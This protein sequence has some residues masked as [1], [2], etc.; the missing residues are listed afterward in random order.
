MRAGGGGSSSSQVP[1]RREVRERRARGASERTTWGRSACGARGTIPDGEGQGGGRGA[2]GHI[3]FRDAHACVAPVAMRRRV[4]RGGRSVA[5]ALALRPPTSVLTPTSG[6][7]ERISKPPRPG[8]ARSTL[9]KSRVAVVRRRSRSRRLRLALLTPVPP[10]VS[11]LHDPLA[12]LT[13]ARTARAVPVA[14]LPQRRDESLC[15]PLRELRLGARRCEA[16]HAGRHPPDGK[17]LE[18][19]LGKGI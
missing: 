11:Q 18:V 1:T 8:K 3:P 5:C 10:H 13:S 17:A 9:G 7:N 4:G 14:V 6:E 2:G 19:C 15:E 16:R 12:R